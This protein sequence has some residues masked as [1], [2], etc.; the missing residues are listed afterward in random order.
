MILC[1]TNKVDELA[2]VMYDD[3]NNVHVLEMAERKKE[4][5]ILKSINSM[6]A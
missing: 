2:K 3:M 6:R 1:I 4:L 5:E